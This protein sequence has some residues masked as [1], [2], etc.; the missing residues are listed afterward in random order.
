MPIKNEREYRDMTMQIEATPE[1]EAKRKMVRGYAS[2]FNQPYTLYEDDDWRFDEVVDSNAFAN[3]DM[4]DVIMQYN[5]EGRV[6]ARMSNNTLTVT[7]DERGLLIEADLSGTELGRQLF[8][9]IEGGYTNKMSFGF[10]VDD[11]KREDTKTP[12]G[13][14][15]TVRTI[16]SVRKLYDVSAVSIPANDATAISIRNLTDGLIEEIQAERLEAEKRER[17]KE[18]LELKIKIMEVEI[19]HE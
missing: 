17:A 19:K 5:H 1:P 9:E 14:R 11:E 6:F 4:Y 2:T 15:M 10:T 18:A 13:K 16:K 3:T 8:E 12:E 7:P